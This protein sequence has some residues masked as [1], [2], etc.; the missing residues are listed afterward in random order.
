MS[1]ELWPFDR[2]SEATKQGFG[3]LQRACGCGRTGFAEEERGLVR[4]L[5]MVEWCEEAWPWVLKLSLSFC[6]SQWKHV[7]EVHIVYHYIIYSEYIRIW[8]IHTNLHMTKNEVCDKYTYM[9]YQWWT[10]QFENFSCLI[11]I[12]QFEINWNY[13]TWEIG[14]FKLYLT[15]NLRTKQGSRVFVLAP[16]GPQG[17]TDYYINMKELLGYA[18]SKMHKVVA[19]EDFMRDVWFAFLCIWKMVVCLWCKFDAIWWNAFS[20]FA[21]VF[22]TAVYACICGP[23]VTHSI[24]VLLG[25]LK[26]CALRGGLGTAERPSRGAMDGMAIFREPSWKVRCKP[27]GCRGKKG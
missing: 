27:G 4:S 21:F 10:Q 20:P 24:G 6:P 7:P 9:L 18:L 3:A 23:S 8:Q 16:R 17:E 14:F 22:Y 26:G 2:K 12:I 1:F 13:R 15:A 25:L 19:E 5:G 11:T